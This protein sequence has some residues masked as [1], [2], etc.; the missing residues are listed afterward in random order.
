MIHSA[1]NA[2]KHS[3]LANFPPAA[4]PHSRATPAAMTSTAPACA[5]MSK[6]R[7]MTPRG[8]LAASAGTLGAACRAAGRAAAEYE[9]ARG[10][11]GIM[12][13]RVRQA[14]PKC[15]ASRAGARSVP[16]VS[17]RWR[18]WRA[19]WRSGRTRRRHRAG[20]RA[21]SLDRPDSAPA[22][23][24][25]VPLERVSAVSRGPPDPRVPYR[26]SCA[27]PVGRSWLLA[28]RDDDAYRLRYSEEEQRR[29]RP[30]GP[31]G[32]VHD[33]RHGTLKVQ[34]IADL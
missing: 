15:Q 8:G 20:P 33:F 9:F 29:Q 27:C 6:L 26:K 11:G 31:T 16:R 18:P 25:V 14:R 10:R 19:A 13:W 1:A 17:G 30:R 21:S 22:E 34:V 12:R 4:W 24:P 32:R 23:S 2:W 3:S 7:G 5:A 28:R